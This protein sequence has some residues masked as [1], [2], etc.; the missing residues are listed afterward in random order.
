[1]PRRRPGVRTLEREELSPPHRDEAGEHGDERRR[2]QD[3]APADTDGRDDEAS[4][5]GPGDLRHVLQ[6]RVQADRV[7]D[8]C[9]RDEL[10]DQRVLARVVEREQH[11]RADG[12][13]ED[14]PEGSGETVSGD[15]EQCDRHARALRP[16][17]NLPV[18]EAVGGDP[19]P[20]TQNSERAVVAQHQQ[21]EEDGR[22]RALEDEPVEGGL[23]D[24][25]PGVGDDLAAEI[26]PIV[27][28]DAQAGE[29]PSPQLRR[30]R[31]RLHKRCARR[32]RRPIGF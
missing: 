12:Q 13:G 11:P 32:F 16:E 10:V 14:D 9:S 21:S 8:L 27:V 1:M 28:V 4:Q 23:G 3:E 17:K 6:G 7:R 19:A 18:V 20:Q 29:D 2:V 26:E 31:N 15:Q 24:L 30:R 22:M 25:R 5:C